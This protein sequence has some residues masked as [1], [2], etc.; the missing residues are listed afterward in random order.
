MVAVLGLGEA[1][2]RLAADLA[3]AGVDV[4]AYDPAEAATVPAGVVRAADAVSAV[5]G[6]GLVLSV[7][8]ASAALAAAQAALPGLRPGALYA[9]LNT[10][11]PARKREIA[12]VVAGA[13]CLFADVALLGPVPRRGLSTPALVSGDGAVALA[14]ALGPLGMPVEVVSPHPGDAARLKLLRSVFMKGLAAAVF[15]SMA[16]AQAAGSAAWLERQ[17]GE[18]I[19]PDLLERLVEGSRRHAT[20]RADEMDAC[21]ELLASL[22]IEPRIAA[23]T[24]AI[25]ADLGRPPGP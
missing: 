13:G 8:T 22:G 24:R 11:G 10:A 21:C 15:E 23:A 12:A 4:H 6:R 5:A 14:E 1:G 19:G 9:D 18:V 2:T 17:I 16:A 7:A 3:A 25:L 20:R